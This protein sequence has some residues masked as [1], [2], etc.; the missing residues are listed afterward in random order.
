MTTL[1][2]VNKVVTDAGCTKTTLTDGEWSADKSEL[3]KVA[4]G[5]LG[6]MHETFT[7]D[8]SKAVPDFDM[9]I[10]WKFY[11]AFMLLNSAGAEVVTASSS[12][13]TLPTKKPA[14][15]T[16]VPSPTPVAAPADTKK[17]KKKRHSCGKGANYLVMGA[18][19]LAASALMLQ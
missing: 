6:E 17:D 5:K 12:W 16:P 9:D 10:E 15:K 1:T 19:T 8:M 7:Y 11:N 4:D 3:V 2:Q 14:E 13:E 18:T